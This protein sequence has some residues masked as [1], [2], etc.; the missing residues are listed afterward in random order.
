MIQRI[1]ER[2][3]EETKLNQWRNTK[4]ALTWFNNIKDKERKEFIQC[5]IE[6]FYPSISEKLLKNSIKFAEKYIDISKTEKDT[7][8]HS[9]KTILVDREDNW[10]KVN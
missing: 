8:L 9:R 4:E 1:N 2:I 7:I 6:D 3:R 10:K 5:D